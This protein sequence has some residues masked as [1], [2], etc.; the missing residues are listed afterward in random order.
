M[1]KENTEKYIKIE[2]NIHKDD[3]D[4]LKGI[5]EILNNLRTPPEGFIRLSAILGDFGFQVTE[6]IEDRLKI[7]EY[8]EE[9]IER[10]ADS[11]TINIP[12]NELN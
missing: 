2:T 5:M 9:Q 3:E 10:Y 6:N 4:A 11:L 12:T 8:F 1:N 7:I